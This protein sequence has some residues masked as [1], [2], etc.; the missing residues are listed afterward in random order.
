MSDIPWWE[1]AVFY[2]VYP[3]SFAD[4]NGDGIGDLPGLI[5]KLDYLQALGIDA[6]WLS[7]H[8][9]SPQIDCGYDIA[10]YVH[11]NP[12]YGTLDDFRKLLDEAH[13]RDL[14]VVT[15]LVLNHTSDQHPWFMES[16]SSKG[17]PRRDWYIWRS[18]RGGL[19][20]NNWLS[21]FGGPAWEFDVTSNEYYYHLFFKEQPDLNWRN[22]AVVEAM[23]TAARFWLDLGVDGFRLDA[24][25]AIFEHP[26]LPDHPVKR[27]QSDLR[28]YLLSASSEQRSEHGDQSQIFQYQVDQPGAVE[29]MGELRSLVETYDNRVLIGESDRV[30]FLGDG[31]NGLHMVFNFPLMNM[32]QLKPANVRENQAQ[33]LSIIPPGGWQANTLGNHDRPRTLQAH[34]DGLHDQEL[35]RVSLALLLTLRGTPFLY[36]GEELGMTNLFLESLSMIRD[37]VST[38]VYQ[39][40][41]EMEISPRSALKKSIH[42]SRDQCRTP[43]QWSNDPNAG[44]SPIGV[45]TWLPVNPDYGQGVNVADQE[46]DP[47]SLLN[48]YRMLLH[49]RRDTSALKWGTYRVTHEKAPDYLA[50]LRQSKLDHQTCLVVL[51][52]S[53]KIHR[54]DF[55][56]E[57]SQAKCLFSTHKSPGIIQNLDEVSLAP[58]EVFIGEWGISLSPTIPDEM[59]CREG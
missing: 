57:A 31:D 56:N 12:E 11:V 34:S 16:R 2:Q 43:M 49:L 22:P 45:T 17:N 51:N 35:A 27:S 55:S 21:A 15:D 20:P 1:R 8:Y 18:G 44:F 7:P 47:D 26:D 10:D 28:H 9:P 41:L 14:K 23:W 32:K 5:Q 53:T 50:Y 30:A 25:D 38:W 19:P 6:I 59:D 3:R 40:A 29:L 4:A 46:N 36:Y 42:Y 52:F 54:L 24:I 39:A 33:R 58:F 37:Q 48:Y 13:Q